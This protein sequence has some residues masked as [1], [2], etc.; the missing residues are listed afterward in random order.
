MLTEVTF[1]RLPEVCRRTGGSKATVY[2]WER[3]DPTFPRRIKLGERLTAWREDE[4][5]AW[6]EARTAAARSAQ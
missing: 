6:I 2:R 1:I 5:A 3:D 4:V